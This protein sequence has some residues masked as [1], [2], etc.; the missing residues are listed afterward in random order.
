MR[1]SNLLRE[2]LPMDSLLLDAQLR[3]RDFLR[4]VLPRDREW[5]EL[6]TVNDLLRSAGRTD[7]VRVKG[8]RTLRF[9]SESFIARKPSRR[10]S[11]AAM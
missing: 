3:L 2:A 6:N 1:L 4:E 9:A 5:N 10:T 7:P 8:R 11:P